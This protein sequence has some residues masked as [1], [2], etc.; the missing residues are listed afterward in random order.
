[1]LFN[2]ARRPLPTPA[3]LLCVVVFICVLFSPGINA[4]ALIMLI[5]LGIAENW[6]PLRVR[7]QETPGIDG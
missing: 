4:L 7:K 3:R 5:L 1:V 2:L 6:L